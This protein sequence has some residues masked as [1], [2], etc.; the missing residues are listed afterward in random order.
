MATP[1]ENDRE[2]TTS[3]KTTHT[4]PPDTHSHTRRWSAFSTARAAE[5]RP[6]GILRSDAGN[7]AAASALCGAEGV[8]PIRALPTPHQLPSPA[9]LWTPSV[10]RACPARAPGGRPCPARRT[11]RRSFATAARQELQV[12][13]REWRPGARQPRSRCRARWRCRMSALPTR[14]S[15][16]GLGHP[17]RWLLPQA[18]GL[19]ASLPQSRLRG[20]T[21]PWR[22]RHGPRRHRDPRPRTGSRA[23]TQGAG[24]GCPSPQGARPGRRLLRCS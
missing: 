21:R 24:Q 14:Q 6:T 11:S 12:A 3:S 10:R 4:T 16:T 7:G 1:L 18:A 17:R 20:Q 13:P 23:C 19:L 8:R 9:W 22:R 5:D 15:S 2:T